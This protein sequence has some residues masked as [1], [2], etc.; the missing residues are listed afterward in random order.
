MREII[1]LISSG[2]IFTKS[3]KMDTYNDLNWNGIYKKGSNSIIWPKSPLVETE[4]IRVSDD[5]FARLEKSYQLAYEHDTHK[6]PQSKWWTNMTKQ[7][8]ETFFTEN[9]RLRIE[10][11]RNFRC[12]KSADTE[13]IT[14]Q[15]SI[16]SKE[17]GYFRS[18][19][20]SIKVVLEY[21]RLSS[22]VRK[23]ILASLSES[24]AGNNYCPIYRGQ[25]LSTALLKHC[26]YLSGILNN[27]NFSEN[28]RNVILE[29]GGAYGGL[30]RTVKNYVPDSCCINIELPEMCVL[31]GY[32]LAYCFPKFKIGFLS[33][34]LDALKTKKISEV[35]NKYDF[36][37]LPTWSIEYFPNKSSDLIVN[38]VS[39]GEMSN[40]YGE[41]YIKN[42]NRVLRQRGYFYSVN[43][44]SS[45][46][47]EKYDDFGFFNWQFIDDYN[48]VSYKYLPIGHPEWIGRKK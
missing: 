39:L 45:T 3:I 22:I 43:R 23:E 6:Y 12:E 18:Y 32:F 35:I 40:E 4:K 24:Y 7:F 15:L 14:Q 17:R 38:T 8:K 41:F 2:K 34:V 46:E 29:I 1:A 20:N 5:V 36:L 28:K 47:V 10:K 33:D 25:R 44:T 19:L 13:I 30:L 16:V 42:I 21:H 11:L 48:T 26:I 27:I 31:S 9:N 37:V